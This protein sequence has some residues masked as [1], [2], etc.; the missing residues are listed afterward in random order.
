MVNPAAQLF[1][2]VSL[3]LHVDTVNILHSILRLPLQ[4]SPKNH[5]G[6]RALFQPLF[7][8]TLSLQ[9]AHTPTHIY[10]LFKAG[11]VGLLIHAQ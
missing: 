11:L 6:A 8:V 7:G 2:I 4:F 1:I 10:F 3:P 9:D 5:F